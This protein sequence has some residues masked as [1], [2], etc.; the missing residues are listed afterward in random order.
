MAPSLSHTLSRCGIGVGQDFGSL[1]SKPRHLSHTLSLCGG[2]TLSVWDLP[3]VPHASVRLQGY[4][5]HTKGT[6]PLGPPLSRACHLPR[7][8]LS[9]Y[10]A[11]SHTHT[12]SLWGL[13]CRVGSQKS[14][15]PS[16]SLSDSLCGVC[17]L[18]RMAQSGYRG[19]SLISY[20][21][22]SL[23]HNTLSVGFGV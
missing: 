10:G 12:T 3:S 20:G 23:S 2:V 22:I 11:I 18:P 21:A 1:E 9:G 7:K 13:G 6:T 17:H 19:T 8:A 16:L 5:A 4:L 14:K 15:P